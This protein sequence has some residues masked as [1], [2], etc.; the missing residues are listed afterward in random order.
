MGEPSRDPNPNQRRDDHPS[1]S[2]RSRRTRMEYLARAPAKAS[3]RAAQV[4]Q[5][6]RGARRADKFGCVEDRS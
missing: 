1:Q 4:Y 5:A 6:N 3:K 2:Q